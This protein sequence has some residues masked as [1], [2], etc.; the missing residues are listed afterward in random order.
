MVPR[1]LQKLG[2]DSIYYV[3]NKNPQRLPE[4][5]LLASVATMGGRMAT[6]CQLLEKCMFVSH[7][8]YMQQKINGFTSFAIDNLYYVNFRI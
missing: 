6:R 4:V 3:H 1:P 7:T 8:K 5:A 2:G